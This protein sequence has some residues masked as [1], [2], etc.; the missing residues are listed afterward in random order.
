MLALLLVAVSAGLSNLAASLGIGVAGV[1]AAT[2]LRVGLVFGAFE[3]AMPLIGLVIGS[4]LASGAGQWARWAGGAV[5]IGMGALAIVRPSRDPAAPAGASLGRL[6]LS[7]LAL[8]LDNLAIGFALGTLHV[9]IVVGALVI[10]A[11]SVAMSLVGLEVGSRVGAA[12][13]RR[14]EQV[15]G[16]ILAGVGA[17]MAAGVL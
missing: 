16:V 15:S 17:A 3:A 8:S 7:G 1:T 9:P 6:L 11:V 10:A 2:R 12:A 5:L 14:G 13:G 4:G